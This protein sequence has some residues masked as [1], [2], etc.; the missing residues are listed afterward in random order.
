MPLNEQWTKI[1]ET[2]TEAEKSHRR[3]RRAS[4]ELA[5]KTG[6]NRA[7]RNNAPFEG[8][9]RDIVKAQKAEEV[10]EAARDALLGEEGSDERALV[11]FREKELR[12][13]ITSMYGKDGIAAKRARLLDEEA[14]QLRRMS[15]LPTASEI[16]ALDDIRGDLSTQ[17]TEENKLLLGS[18]EAFA[19]LHLFEL[20]KYKEQLE[21]GRIAETPYVK[22][23]I[24][25]LLVHFRTGVPLLVYG[26]LGSG[27]TE[28]CMHIAREYIGKD[29]LVISGSKNISL[30]EFYGHQVLA[31]DKIDTTELDAFVRS[32]EQKHNEWVAE[33][34]DAPE[35]ERQR[36]HDRYLHIYAQ[37][38]KGGTV[39]QYFLGPIYRAMQEGRPIIV[40]EVNAIPHEILI[41]LNHILTRRIGDI[42]PVQQDSGA[43]V[44]VQ[45]GF[46]VMMTANLNQEQERYID[47]QDLDPAFLSRLYK[48][49]YNY[50]PQITRGSLAEAKKSRGVENDLFRILLARVMDAH[51]DMALPSGSPEKLWR[52]AQAARITQDVFAGRD[53]DK[54]YYFTQGGSKAVR[55][56]LKEGVCSPRALERIVTTW[57]K[58]GFRYELDRAIWD[59]FIAQST[60]PSDQAYLYQLFK[61]QF[62]FFKSDGW[63][64][65]PSYG[66]GGT[67]LLFDIKA[68][69]NE[70][71]SKEYT[72]AR[73]TVEMCFGPIPKRT[74]F[75]DTTTSKKKTSKIPEQTPSDLPEKL[76]VLQND[77]EELNREMEVLGGDVIDF[78]KP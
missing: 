58:D 24:E 77:F 38:I 19:G 26:H 49:E 47:R 61:D 63:D 21:N 42:V 73:E 12:A 20:K 35:E 31:I 6:T 33:H 52:L 8:G 11:S 53:I 78:L 60:V 13:A 27:K 66:S 45:E 40:D 7:T 15:E 76:S 48:K 70:S 51:G 65:A 2:V 75:P 44:S 68:P 74:R 9:T 62:G 54:A 5:L 39:S 23:Q 10:F 25:D 67:V 30:A 16:E 22:E 72:S 37:G 29:A 69:K 55:Y 3:A 56:A 50:L 14:D 32:V 34:A 41:S 43:S 46:G 59:D 17:R 1:E 71:G 36:A 64:Q 4:Q 18:P 28:L 57:I